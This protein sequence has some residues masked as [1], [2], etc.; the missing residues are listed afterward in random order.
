[1]VRRP[2]DFEIDPVV[3]LIPDTPKMT[4]D[5]WLAALRTDGP[6]EL[7]VSAA[8]LVAEARAEGE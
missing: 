4:M 6:T 7:S 5:E 3:V 8:E 1:M 2:E